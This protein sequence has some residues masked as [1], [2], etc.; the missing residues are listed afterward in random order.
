MTLRAT[1]RAFPAFPRVQA[2]ARFAA[3]TTWLLAPICFVLLGTGRETPPPAAPV[4]APDALA[5]HTGRWVRSDGA[6]VQ[7]LVTTAPERTPDLARQRAAVR[8]ALAA[9]LDADLSATMR[10]R[11]LPGYDSDEEGDLDPGEKLLYH[12]VI[13]STGGDPATN[14]TFTMPSFDAGTTLVPGSRQTS[15]LALDDTYD[16]IGN[17]P[18]VIDAANG[19]IQGGAPGAT[20]DVDPDPGAVLSVVGIGGCADVEAPFDCTTENGG[21]VSMTADGA[22]TY[23]PAAGFEGFDTFTYELS[24]GTTLPDDALGKDD[25]DLPDPMPTSIA[26]VTIMVSEV[27]W[28]VDAD[29][30][31]GTGHAHA[32]FNLD[33]LNASELDEAGDFIYL[34]SG[35]H[36]STAAL[37]LLEGQKLVGEGVSL[38]DF[39]LAN[40]SSHT[41][42]PVGVTLPDAG[43]APVVTSAA[44]YVVSLG[45]GNTIAGLTL[46]P[47]VGAGILASILA[48][49][50]DLATLIHDVT[51]EIGG[52]ASDGIHLNDHKGPF[53]FDSGAIV[54]AAGNDASTGA[55]IRATSVSGA[56]RV[57]ASTIDFSGGRIIDFTKVQG[58]VDFDG[59]VVTSTDHSGVRISNSGG[60]F[61][62]LPALT[63]A[64]ETP[65]TVDAISLTTNT[66]ANFYFGPLVLHTNGARGI[67]ASDTDSYGGTLHIADTTSSIIA[68]GA[69]ALD[70]RYVSLGNGNS[71]AMTFADVSSSGS[72]GVGLRLTNVSGAL[73][74]NGGAITNP[75]ST[76]YSETGIMH[77]ERGG[78]TATI[79]YGGSITKTG[80]HGNAVYVNTKRGGVTTFGGTITAQTGSN[81]AINLVN[82]QGGTISFPGGLSL[83]TTGGT[84]FNATGAGTVE[85]AGGAYTIETSTG[86]ALHLDDV[87]AGASGISFDTVKTTGATTQAIFIHNSTGTKSLHTLNLTTSNQTGLFASN[88]GTIHTTDGTI[89]AGQGSGVDIDNTN[90]DVTLTT[91]NASG[92]SAPGI[93]LRTTTGSFAVTGVDGGACMTN[94]AD[95]TG[96][97]ITAKSGN[98]IHLE[99]ASGV[100]LARMHLQGNTDNGIYGQNVDGF[101][102]N[103]L[104]VVENGSGVQENGLRFT[105]LTGQASLTNILVRQSSEHNVSITNTSG[106]LN[107]AVAGS[108]FDNTNLVATGADG[109]FIEMQETAIG[110]LSVLSSTFENNRSD[111]LQGAAIDNARLDVVVRGNTFNNNYQGLVLNT[112]GSGDL[113]FDVGGPTPADG[114]TLTN[115]AGTSLFVGTTTTATNGSIVNGWIRHNTISDPS[116]ALDQTG[117]GPKVNHVVQVLTSGASNATIEVADNSIDNKGIFQGLIMTAADVAGA[118]SNLNARV[119]NNTITSPS[120]VAANTLLVQARYTGTVCARI[121]GNTATNGGIGFGIRLRERD[122]SNVFLERGTSGSSVPTTV[123]ND[124]NPDATNPDASELEYTDLVPSGTCASPAS[125]AAMAGL[126]VAP[127]QAPAPAP[128]ADPSVTFAAAPATP[129]AAMQPDVTAPSQNDVHLTVTADE[130]LAAT[131]APAEVE[132]LLLASAG[133]GIDALA[134]ARARVQAREA[135]AVTPAPAPAAARA[136]I[137]GSDF[138]VALGMMPAGREV[139]VFFEV[140]VSDPVPAGV[141]SVSNQGIV[142][143]DGGIEVLTDDPDV[144]GVQDPTVTAL[145]AEALLTLAQSADT[146]TIAPGGLL[147]YTFTYGNAGNQSVDGAVLR[148][149]VPAGTAFDDDATTA[150]WVCTDTDDDADPNDAGSIC[151]LSGLTVAG[152]VGGLTADFAVTVLTP[153]AAGLETIAHEAHL[154]LDDDAVV[155]G[156]PAA[157]SALATTLVAVPDLSLTKSD[158]GAEGVAPGQTIMYTLHY[159]NVGNQDATGVVLTETVPDHTHLNAAASTPGWSCTPGGEAGATCTLAVGALAGGANGTAVFA[160]TVDLPLAPGIASVSNTASVTDDG[161]GGA[162]PNDTDNVATDDT[163]LTN[164]YGPVINEFDYEQG[165]T[166]LAEFVEIYNP[167]TAGIALDA[168]ELRFV[169]HINGVDPY[170]SIPLPAD[171]LSPGA[172][173]LACVNDEAFVAACGLDLGDAPVMVDEGPAAVALVHTATGIVVDAVSYEGDVPGYT[174]GT[175]IATGDDG[176]IDF[177]GFSRSP[178][179]AD[180]DDNAADFVAA[181]VTPGTPNQADL[182]ECTDPLPVE[183]T[184]FTATADGGAVTLHWTTASE[185]NNAGFEVEHRM[186][187]GAAWHTLGFV[188]GAG[189]TTQPRTYT[190]RVEQAAPGAHVFRLKQVDYDGSFAYSP[191]VEVALDVPRTLTLLQNYPNPFNPVTTIAFTVPESGRAVVRVFNLLGQQVA[192]LHDAVAEA[193][194]LHEVRLDASGLSTGLYVYTLEHNGQRLARQ[195]SLIK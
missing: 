42:I 169:P 15:P 89:N 101:H 19:V 30:T 142:T 146:E 141:T 145:D 53:T 25:D 57:T 195:L 27:I 129:S 24:D 128:A 74:I 52:P 183:L 150:A 182:A 160:V 186:R 123:L 67:H 2:R 79:H 163:P 105:N 13:T 177:A 115:H 178:D 40:Q 78:S 88:A 85:V 11:I 104:Y 132:P 144:G 37:Q 90:L 125:F 77:G 147:T 44:A 108:R 120:S 56:L 80:G 171:V 138:P 126:H 119:L 112:A 70:L 166:D 21:T 7:R 75:D 162:D 28:F 93:D 48:G 156:T 72:R 127:E 49:S 170:Q 45:N 34:Y 180:T 38:E 59:T 29:A 12:V 95:C 189:T 103:D 22:F 143:A 97:A 117:S 176:A 133:G 51:I 86:R 184:S 122:A 148:T 81:N 68:T 109:F 62:N 18:L 181:C 60:T 4:A 23:I 43:V 113:N 46:R 139:H 26:T 73:T 188:A 98:G 32:P 8:A 71:G 121:E 151:T 94:A 31:E 161:A 191:L 168:Y 6:H 106:T 114:N 157:T 131:E 193:G 76:A 174:E 159:A 63:I 137:P 91:V 16:A 130:A 36:N 3:F 69:P 66:K 194:R 154:Y 153:A 84:A 155:A 61:A 165:D 99:N 107:L 17:V 152:G 110:T 136:A 102:A 55:A 92:G 10:G 173:F 14:V 39:F 5:V 33:A 158:G 64:A 54:M 83:T 100:S 87:N 35:T 179:G 50:K 134:L 96:G 135:R 116:F 1:S 58:G 9:D 164:P 190:F 82:N 187:E 65:A 111:G 185:T 124:N 172:F 118:T 167:T 20:A 47:T 175:G 192:V 149:V 41:A 140:Q